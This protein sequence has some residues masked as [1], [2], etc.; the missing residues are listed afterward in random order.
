MLAEQSKMKIDVDQ[1]V[2]ILTEESDAV[3]EAVP[4]YW[5][6]LVIKPAY[7]ARL[8]KLNNDP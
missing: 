4:N 8:R 2:M 7:I 5:H 3:K 1:T 6:R